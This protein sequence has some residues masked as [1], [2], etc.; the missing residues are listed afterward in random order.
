MFPGFDFN[1]AP[2][3]AFANE[4]ALFDPL[5]D[6]VLGVTQLANQPD[7]ST[8]RTELNRLVNGYPDDPSVSGTVRAGLLNSLPPG[9]VNDAQ[10]TRAIA[11]A[12]CS[13]A[14]GNAAMLVQ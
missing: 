8:A 1:S 7:K 5:L 6:R 14:V 11:K 13:S 2:A 12:V 3:A 4:N 10:R 9:Q